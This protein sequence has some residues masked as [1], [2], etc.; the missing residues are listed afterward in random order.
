MK[1]IKAMPL[2]PNGFKVNEEILFAQ[3]VF[4]NYK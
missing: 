1:E 3:D 4:L 2:D